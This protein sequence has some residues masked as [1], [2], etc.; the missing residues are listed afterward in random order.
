MPDEKN[1][2]NVNDFAVS[3]DL[4]MEIKG[5]VFIAVTSTVTCLPNN[6][7]SYNS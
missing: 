6:Y 1:V 3:I 2:E 4:L 5:C 7:R